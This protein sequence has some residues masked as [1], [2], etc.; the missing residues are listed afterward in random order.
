MP[1]PR[2][3]IFDMDG[4]MFNTEDVYTVVGTEVLRRRGCAFT[5]DL[6]NALMGLTAQA[7][8]QTMID[9]HG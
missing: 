9:W 8:F 3:A 6:K 1:T 4:L 7:A 2:A 5:E